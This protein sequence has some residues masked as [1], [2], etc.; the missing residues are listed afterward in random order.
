MAPAASRPATAAG[1]R[2]VAEHD[3]HRRQHDDASALAPGPSGTACRRT[4]PGGVDHEH[5]RVVEVSRRVRPRCRAQEQR[6]AGRQARSS[7]S[8]ELLALALDG[9]APRDRRCR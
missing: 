6:V 9:R 1:S 3:D 5:G 2:P 7:P 8:P 4:R